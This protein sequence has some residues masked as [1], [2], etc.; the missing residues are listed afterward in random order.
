MINGVIALMIGLYLILVVW[1]GNESRMIA[2]ISD[3]VGFLKWGG[4]LLTAAYIYS[5][6][7]GKTG[8]IIKSFIIIALAAMLLKNGEKMFGE[9]DKL[10]APVDNRKIKM[11]IK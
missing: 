8:E 11:S 10:F 5:N 9:F 4:A 1:Q 2:T 6:V 7:D 3:Q